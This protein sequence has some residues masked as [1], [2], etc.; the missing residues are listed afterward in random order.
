MLTGEA[1]S[2]KTRLVYELYQSL[3]PAPLLLAASASSLGRTLPFQIITQIIRDNLVL[4]DRITDPNWKQQVSRLM[5]HIFREGTPYSN[6][7]SL[8]TPEERMFLFE[9]IHRYLLEMFKGE[10]VLIFLDNCQWLDDSSME[11][12]VYLF[13]KDFFQPTRLMVLAS[14]PDTRKLELEDWHTGLKNSPQVP[15]ITLKPLD[16]PSIGEMAGYMLGKSPSE[17]TIQQLSKLSGGNPYFLIE[18]LR[19]MRQSYP[20]LD[21]DQN[22]NQI[23]LP[24]SIN[25]LVQ[26]RLNALSRDAQNILMAASVI[27]N[28]FTPGQLEEIS[29]IQ[30]ETIVSLLEELESAHFIQPSDNPPPGGSYNFIHEII[31]EKIYNGLSLARKRL[32]H[33]KVART[34]ENGSNPCPSCHPGVSL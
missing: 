9:D 10:K 22:L 33:Q 6:P 14:R 19:I 34:L 25:V 11:L 8:E 4:G 31:P 32:L 5:P 3:K 16:M 15:L 21:A 24:K 7:Q 13:K 1:G 30:P 20:F 27:R 18:T 29:G 2:G 26:D 17:E 12:L 28:D 23:Q